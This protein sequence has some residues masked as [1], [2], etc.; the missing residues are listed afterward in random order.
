MSGKMILLLGNHFPIFP[1]LKKYQTYL[2]EIQAVSKYFA[3]LETTEIMQRKILKQFF[4]QI[5]SFTEL[6]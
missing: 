6:F 3:F 1:D 4:S 5:C 2:E